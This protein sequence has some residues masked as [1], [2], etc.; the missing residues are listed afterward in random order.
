[1]RFQMSWKKK[2]NPIVRKRILQ[3]NVLL[4]VA[5]TVESVAYEHV[6][7]ILKLWILD[8]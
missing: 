4:P 1:M 8:Y 7:S 5:F 6:S 3:L 2:I